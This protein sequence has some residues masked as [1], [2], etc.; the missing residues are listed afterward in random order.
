[1][2]RGLKVLIALGLVLAGSALAFAGAAPQDLLTVTDVA[3]DP[4]AHAGGH[5]R[6][7][8]AIAEGSLVMNGTRVTF[9]IVD[10][11]HRLPVVWT[12]DKPL[13]GGEMGV[14][15]RTAVLEG[16]LVNENGAWTILATDLAIGCASKYESE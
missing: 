13:P 10:G 8:A 7:K 4:A 1:M 15:G 2:R 6:M 11:D 12:P 5:L 9:D 3:S 14:E 16:R